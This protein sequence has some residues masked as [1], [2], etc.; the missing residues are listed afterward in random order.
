MQKLKR[1]YHDIERLD[2]DF[3]IYDV[4][5]VNDRSACRCRFNVLKILKNIELNID[6]T[7]NFSGKKIGIG[8]TTFNRFEVLKES[9]RRIK[10]F[11]SIPCEIFV[12]DDGS[13]DNTLE[14]LPNEDGIYYFSG[15]NRGVAWNKN[16]CLFFFRNFIHVDV[17]ILLDDDVHVD[18]IGWEQNFVNGAIKYLLTPR[19]I[20]S[21][22]GSENFS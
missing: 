7:N 8:I 16:R 5:D 17:I 21:G 15:R 12:A 18:G 10:N 22:S 14:F 9:I 20:G 6:R 3:S 2:S 4:N 11:T 13:I 19:L 1:G